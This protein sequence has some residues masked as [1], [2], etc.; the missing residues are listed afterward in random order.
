MTRLMTE[1]GDANADD[2]TNTDA[3]ELPHPN[4]E[5]PP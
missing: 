3:C 4:R 2:L 5:A 1:E